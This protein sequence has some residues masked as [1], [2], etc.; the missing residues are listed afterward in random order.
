MGHG[1]CMGN[2]WSAAGPCGLLLHG[3]PTGLAKRSSAGRTDDV[4]PRERNKS[5]ASVIRNRSAN[6]SPACS[7]R[8]EEPCKKVATPH[9]HLVQCS[10]SQPPVRWTTW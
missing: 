8:P 6:Q 9:Q 10:D 5:W 3:L 1:C 4:S 2:L 7:D